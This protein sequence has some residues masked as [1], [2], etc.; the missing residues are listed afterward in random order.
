MTVRVAFATAP[1]ATIGH[2][3]TDRPYHDAAC[4][5]AGVAL[6]HAVWSDPAVRWEDYDLVVVRS[7]WDYLDH[8][9]AYRTWLDRVGH[10]GTLH[11]P[12][13]VIGWNLD[14]RYLADLADAGLPVI[15]TRVCVDA[16]EV[17]GALAGTAGEVVVKP[18]VSAGSRRTGRF[19]AGDPAAV[20]LAAQILEEGTT[21]LVQPAVRS[22]ATEGEVSTVVFGGRVSHTVRKGPLLALGGGLVGGT[23][24]ERLTPEPLTPARRSVVEATVTAVAHLVAD[25]FGVRDPLL[26][27]RIDV[28]AL[29]DGTEV[30][31]EVELAEPAF[32]LGTDPA[33]AGRFADEVV[34][35]ATGRR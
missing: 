8:I 33:A 25:R 3:D 35:R 4:A 34:R 13:P 14:K 6:D 7:T 21:V 17:A 18:A 15:P 12:A 10:L 23:Y 29:D 32:F 1:D 2:N 11:N 5:A 24:S 19:A 20:S 22:V 9:D 30:V 31:R 27:A 26:Y 28:V 16:G